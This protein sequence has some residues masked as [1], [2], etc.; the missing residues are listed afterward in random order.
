MLD[1]ICGGY[2]MVVL[3]FLF[4]QKHLNRSAF[5]RSFT[6]NR[7]K[8]SRLRGK[9][10]PIVNVRNCLLSPRVVDRGAFIVESFECALMLG[11]L[12]QH[13]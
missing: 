13:V 2:H 4:G 11:M 3:A 5:A 6:D 9:R 7:N 12:S 10:H 1:V 8:G